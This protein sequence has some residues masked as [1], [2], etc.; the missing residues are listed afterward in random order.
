YTKASL[1]LFM[2]HP[3][4]DEFLDR[5]ATE[6]NYGERVRIMRDELGPWLHEYIPGVAIGAAHNIAGLGP[7]VGEW[8]VIQGHIRFHNW[9][10]V[11]RAREPIAGSRR[12]REE[13]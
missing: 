4:L 7:K 6:P 13:A 11:T 9:A 10:D 1:N 3:K 2:E 12:E 5:L 8:P